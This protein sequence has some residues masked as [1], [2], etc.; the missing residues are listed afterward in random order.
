MN[1]CQS[2]FLLDA[3]WMF[4]HRFVGH[5]ITQPLIKAFTSVKHLLTFTDASLYQMPNFVSH[6]ETPLTL[7][8]FVIVS[9]RLVYKSSQDFVSKHSTFHNRASMQYENFKISQEVCPGTLFEALWKQMHRIHRLSGGR[10][11]K[12][13]MYS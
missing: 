11:R 10:F 7:R 6:Q 1:P 2:Y 9:S 4:T 12:F 3:Y 13:P 8:V 5:F